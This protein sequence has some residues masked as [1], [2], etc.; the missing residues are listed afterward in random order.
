MSDQGIRKAFGFGQGNDEND[1][2]EVFGAADDEMSFAFD[3]RHRAPDDGFDPATLVGEMAR[4]LDSITRIGGEVCRLRA[5]MDGLLD[6]NKVL[7]ERFERLREVIEEKG[8]LNMD[9]FDLACE[10]M[11]MRQSA[12]AAEAVAPSPTKKIAH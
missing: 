2:D 8:T 4:L 5:E 12:T 9:D 11:T 3:T 6:T 1:D 10:V 7:G